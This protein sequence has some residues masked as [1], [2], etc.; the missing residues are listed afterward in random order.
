[1][2]RRAFLAGAAALLAAPLAAEAQQVGKARIGF[3]PAIPEPNANTEAFREALRDLGHIDGQNILIDSRWGYRFREDAE[4]LVRLKAAVI[5]AAGSP[6]VSAVA[7]ATQTIPTV[8]IDLE[9]DPVASGFVMSLA[10]PGGNLAGLFP[11][12]PGLGGKLLDL[13]RSITRSPDPPAA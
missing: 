8:A 10:R 1:M 6:T 2:D 13:M 4:D 5:V 12:F 7:K 9:S 3:M 11:R